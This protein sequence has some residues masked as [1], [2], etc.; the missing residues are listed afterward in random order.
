MNVYTDDDF[1]GDRPEP[2]GP[3]YEPPGQE[4]AARTA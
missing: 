3:K 1:P 4:R 2:R